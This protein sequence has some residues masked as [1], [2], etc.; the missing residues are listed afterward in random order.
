MVSCVILRNETEERMDR[1][2][3][4][5]GTTADRERI[6]TLLKMANRPYPC[7]PPKKFRFRTCKKI[8]RI[9]FI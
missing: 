5:S 8:I 7:S 6:G 4:E 3:N 9:F 2:L 1:E